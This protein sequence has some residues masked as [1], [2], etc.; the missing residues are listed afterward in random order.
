MLLLTIRRYLRSA[1]AALALTF[2]VLA[3]Q[4]QSISVRFDL[5]ER[6]GLLETYDVFFE[7][8][9]SI[10]SGQL[11]LNV[12]DALVT[13]DSIQGVFP[14]SSASVNDNRG[15]IIASPSNGPDLMIGDGYRVGRAYFSLANSSVRGF[16]VSLT[17]TEFIGPEPDFDEYDLATPTINLGLSGLRGARELATL[18]LAPSLA[19]TTVRVL[20]QTRVSYARVF[21]LSGRSLR[22]L[23]AEDNVFDVTAL[24]PGRYVLQLEGSGGELLGIAQLGVQR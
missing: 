23:T 14:E 12:D 19:T 15:V 9:T 18:Q 3:S 22:R 6:N 11:T 7:G 8:V 21:D 10:S 1:S 5:V 24:A 2:G 20:G 13:I 17:N 4:A 16:T